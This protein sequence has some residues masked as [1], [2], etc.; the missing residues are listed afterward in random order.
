MTLIKVPLV[1]R[2]TVLAVNILFEVSAER[3]PFF[4]GK[5]ASLFNECDQFAPDQWLRYS[6]QDYED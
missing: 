3:I 5:A 4:A 1:N 2:L 6:D